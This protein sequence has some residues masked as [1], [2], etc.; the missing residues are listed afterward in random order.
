MRIVPVYWAAVLLDRFYR[1]GLRP[2]AFVGDRCI[3]RRKVDEPHSLGT[4]HERVVAHAFFVELRFHRELA[5]PVEASLGAVVETGREQLRGGEIPGVFQRTPQ[6]NGARS[7]AL[8]VLRRPET[9]LVR[10]DRRPDR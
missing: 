3:E 10:V 1:M 4:E 9:A 6:C 8:V 5:D 2:C 7:A